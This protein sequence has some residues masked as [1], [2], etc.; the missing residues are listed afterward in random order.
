MPV[1]VVPSGPGSESEAI[2]QILINAIY[3]AD[4]DLLITMP[5]F[6]LNESLQRALISA[7]RRGVKATLVVPQRVD[8][9]LVRLASRPFLR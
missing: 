5:Y 4:H 6:V 8:S 3:I 2:V 1:Q 7:A 9:R